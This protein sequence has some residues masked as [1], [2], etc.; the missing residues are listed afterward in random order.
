MASRRRQRTPAGN[1]PAW[2]P[3]IPPWR[4]S[5]EERFG[6]VFLIR[7][8]G[9]SAEEILQSLQERLGNDPGTERRIA[10]EQLREI[11]VLRLEQ[12]LR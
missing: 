8:A 2:T 10:A 12:E 9:R 3:A 1:N 7:A 11:A 6:H 5:Y 4:S